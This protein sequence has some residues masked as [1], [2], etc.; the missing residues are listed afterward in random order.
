M[1]AAPANAELKVDNPAR[2]AQ[3]PAEPAADPVQDK[4]RAAR[5]AATR[6]VGDRVHRERQEIP[7]TLAGA[8]PRLAR[9]PPHLSAGAAS[10][11]RQTS[12]SAS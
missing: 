5:I 3:E 6:M 7:V 10:R 4:A 11:L 9:Q 8:I 1:L 12:R 2:A